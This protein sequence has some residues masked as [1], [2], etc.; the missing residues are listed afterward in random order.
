MIFFQPDADNSAK[1]I[2]LQPR[3]STT[4]QIGFGMVGIV[5]FA[6]FG[7]IAYS[8]SRELEGLSAYLALAA[9]L[10]FFLLSAAALYGTVHVSLTTRVTAPILE[11]ESMELTR[12]SPVAARLIQKGPAAFHE[13]RV[14]LI[15]KQTEYEE[16]TQETR[17]S[18]EDEGPYET[19]TVILERGETEL[20]RINLFSLEELRVLP[21]DEVIHPFTICVPENVVASGSDQVSEYVSYGYAW[22]LIVEGEIFG[23]NPKQEYDVTV[24]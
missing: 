8:A 23:P 19:E 7:F 3:E 17:R 14:V 4:Q 11:L 24:V 2:R 5:L 1:F 18:F 20:A 22:K 13:L 9:S 15:C 10:V 12:G 6:L 16:V 21:G